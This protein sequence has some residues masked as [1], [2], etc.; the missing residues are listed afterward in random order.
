MIL[1]RFLQTQEHVGVMA[2][3]VKMLYVTG[4]TTGKPQLGRL[5]TLTLPYGV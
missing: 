2:G 4:I 1:A 5:K 3:A